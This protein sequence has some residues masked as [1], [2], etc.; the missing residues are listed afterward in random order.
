MDGALPACSAQLWESDYLR[1]TN[2][3]REQKCEGVHVWVSERCIHDGVQGASKATFKC[4]WAEVK[5][6]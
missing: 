2:T 1:V 4:A 3:H 5:R 6:K